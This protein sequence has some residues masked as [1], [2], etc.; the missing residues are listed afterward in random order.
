MF[1]TGPSTHTRNPRLGHITLNRPDWAVFLN[2]FRKRLVKRL[3][4]NPVNRIGETRSSLFRSLNRS[5]SVID[6]SVDAISDL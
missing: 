3:V 6:W 1:Y 5:S 2:S 4:K